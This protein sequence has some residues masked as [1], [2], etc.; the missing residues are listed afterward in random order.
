VGHQPET[1]TGAPP[2]AEKAPHP[3]TPEAPKEPARRGDAGRDG[4]PSIPPV[5]VDAPAGPPPP[6]KGG[7]PPGKQ[8]RRLSTRARILAGVGVVLILVIVA[9]VVSSQT[10][11]TTQCPLPGASI[12]TSPPTGVVRPTKAVFQEDFSGR[13]SG[14]TDAGGERAGGHYTNGTYRIC[15]EA[16]DEG[17]SAGSGPLKESSLYPSAP[18]NL[19][20]EVDARRLTGSKDTGYG[21]FCR[22]GRNLNE[23]GYSFIIWNGFVSIAKYFDHSPWYSSFVDKPIPM[24]DANA[25]NRL[26]VVCSSTD[27]QQGVHLAFSLNGKLIA[28]W[29]DTDNTFPAGTVGLLVATGPDATTAVEAEFDNFVVKQV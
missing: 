2:A 26:Q 5:V 23:G 17:G 28:E 25:T 22:A 21:I 24:L 6:S 15:A 11:S 14:W 9:I 19:R 10:T 7:K 3:S 13:V 12:T 4:M 27:R 20:I 1:R 29:N 16:V 18:S 8:R